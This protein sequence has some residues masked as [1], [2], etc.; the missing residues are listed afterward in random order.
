MRIERYMTPAEDAPR[1]IFAHPV[2]ALGFRPFFLLAG[3]LAAVWLPL[4]LHVLFSGTTLPLAV[5][6]TAWHAHEMIFG[7]AVA[8]IAGFL[9][10]AASQGSS[11]NLQ[12]TRVAGPG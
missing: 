8:V 1:G 3:L 12:T 6:P 2:L 10:T 4:W 11:P 9:L 5:D 7:F